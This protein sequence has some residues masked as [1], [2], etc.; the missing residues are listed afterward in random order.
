MKRTGNKMKR[1]EN[2]HVNGIKQR[3]PKAVK[4]KET[5]G[6]EYNIEEMKQ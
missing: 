4:T 3:I 5:Q 6:R 2:K 1:T